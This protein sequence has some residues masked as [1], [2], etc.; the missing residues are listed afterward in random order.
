MLLL[1]LLSACKENPMSDIMKSIK[2]LWMGAQGLASSKTGFAGVRGADAEK[3]AKD[4]A[5][6]LLDVRTPGEYAEGRI[7][8][9]TLVPV[10]ELANRLAELP[11]DKEKPILV[12]CAM[13]GR[14]ARAATVLASNGWTTV[15]NLE[16]GITGWREEGR[17]V[18]K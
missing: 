10:D 1:L 5:V 4:P 17:P 11:A 13:G 16:G 7:E 14:S 8:R 12:Y 18:T 15:F 2:H 3:L 9:G 6:F